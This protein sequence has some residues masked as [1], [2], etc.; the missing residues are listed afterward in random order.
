MNHKDQLSYLPYIRLMREKEAVIKKFGFLLTTKDAE[1]S[2]PVS[3]VCLAFLI[4]Y[5]NLNEPAYPRDFSSKISRVVEKYLE[6]EQ[7]NVIVSW[8]ELAFILDTRKTYRI[9]SALN[10]KIATRY[11]QLSNARCDNPLL[12]LRLDVIE[13]VCHSIQ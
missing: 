4:D 11:A 7:Q 6:D 5:D 2:F 13:K 1:L 12:T 8:E 10:E 3:Q 9:S